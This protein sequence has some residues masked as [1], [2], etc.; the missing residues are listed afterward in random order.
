MMVKKLQMRWIR[1]CFLFLFFLSYGLKSIYLCQ[2]SDEKN[3]SLD[4]KNSLF[5]EGHAVHILTTISFY[6]LV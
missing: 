1:F 2:Q 6:W 4:R 5:L 3:L